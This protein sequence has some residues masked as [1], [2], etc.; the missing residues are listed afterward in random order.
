M[1]SGDSSALHFRVNSKARPEVYNIVTDVLNNRYLTYDMIGLVAAVPG[2]L[3]P[4]T[5]S[6]TVGTLPFHAPRSLPGVYAAGCNRICFVF[7]SRVHLHR[8]NRSTD[9]TVSC[10]CPALQVRA[11][12]G[13]ADGLGP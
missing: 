13:T 8:T 9:H 5:S 2:R 11:V 6:P 3:L 7:L 12:G 4:G 10:C 1:C